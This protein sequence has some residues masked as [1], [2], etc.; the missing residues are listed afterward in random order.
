M[1]KN[2]TTERMPEGFKPEPGMPIKL[3]LLRWKL[4]NKAKQEPKFRFYALYDRIYRRDTLETAYRRIRRN[5]GGPGIDKITFEM[6]ESSEG[7]AKQL[8]SDLGDELKARTYRPQPVERVYIPKGNGKM[9]PLGIPCIRDRLVQMAVVLILEPIFE[10]DFQECSFGFRPKRKAHDAL[11][12][13]KENLKQGFSEVYDADLSSYFDTVD[14][15]KL[16]ILLKQRIADRSV[17]KL[18]RM[19]LRSPIVEKD[20]DGNTTVSKP[21]KGT[22]QGGVISPLLS[23]IY[24]NY[25]DTAFKRDPNSPGNTANAKLIRYAD[26][27][28]I[29]ARYMGEKITNWVEKIIEEKLELSINEEKTKILKVKAHHDELSFL[30]FTF[31][32]DRDI[33]GRDHHY[34]NT[35]PS[36][37]AQA[38]IREKIRELTKRGVNRPFPEVIGRVN[39]ATTGWKNYFSKGY[40]RVAYRGVNYYLQIRFRRFFMNRS[41]RKSK[42]FRD[43]ETMYKG[44][45]RLG[46]K[47]L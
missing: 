33:K 6:I 20:Q 44:L 16:M 1:R 34:L 25:L 22:P 39:M 14:H 5:K 7:G 37:K 36:K 4:G 47:Y 11:V 29:M 35:F 12:Q 8:I 40:P 32:Y 19:W 18:I 45:R 13:I 30:G 3:S 42:V 43:G 27:F 38:S 17:L 15:T 23:N 28:V 2:S 10:E 21:K 26:D 41:Q 24:L 46:L 9:R 31:R